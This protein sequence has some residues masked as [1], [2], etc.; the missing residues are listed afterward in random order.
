MLTPAQIR[1]LKELLPI[2]ALVIII[3]ASIYYIKVS[4]NQEPILV[5]VQINQSITL[6]YP[7]QNVNPLEIDYDIDYEIRITNEGGGGFIPPGQRKK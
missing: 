4:D 5:N 3:L 6:E 2:I 1:A 7:E